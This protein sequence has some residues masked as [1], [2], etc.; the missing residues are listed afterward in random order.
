MLLQ[1][2]KPARYTGGEWNTI[3]K[4]WDKTALKISLSYPDI[5][6]IGMSNMAISILYEFFN[7]QPDVL[8]ERVFAPWVDMMQALR[9]EK[10]PL[11]S[12]ESRHA[13]REF[14]VI[15]FS[16][17]YELTFTNILSILDLAGIPLW[18]K[19][20]DDSYPLI[21]AGGSSC[22]NPEPVADF[23]DLFVIGEAEEL[24]PELICLLKEAKIKGKRLAKKFFLHQAAG[25][26]GIYVPSLYQASYLDGKYQV[27][28][29]LVPEA[30]P[31]IRRQLVSRMPQAPVKPIVPFIEI[32]HD[33]A[34]VEISRGCTRG[35]RFCNAGIIYRPVRERPMEEILKAVDDSISNTGYDEISLVSL[36]SGDYSH[37]DELVTS[38]AQK[39]GSN[40]A[41]SLPSLRLDK[42]AVNLVDRLPNRR[43]SGLTFAPEAG[44]TRLQKVINKFIPE[45]ELLAA[46]AS[47]FE[48]GWLGLKLYFMLGLPT[49]TNDDAEGIA[50]LTKK[51]QAQSRQRLPQIRL[52]IS[53][54]VPKPH[55]P[56]QWAAQES[57]EKLLSRHELLRKSLGKHGIKLSYQDTR[58]SLME[59]VMS[60]GDRRL[61]Q[62][63]Y[64]AWQDGAV[65]DGWRECFNFER[66]QKA[67]DDC[68]LDT[69]F[70]ARR[71]HAMDEPL[72]WAHIDT[73]IS[74]AFL[75]E[76]HH[77]A[78]AGELTPD[79][80]QSCNVCGLQPTECGQKP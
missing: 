39:Y 3:R 64:R 15:G 4:D 59:A 12:L 27:L 78:M 57:E 7:N 49:E 6:E 43:K 31:T 71:E 79:C 58:L 11:V 80:R 60:R 50:R 35:C 65:F 2:N 5:Y 76:E 17:G 40:L 33:R 45:E 42:H 24:L 77:R 34:A 30:S 8:A 38:I 69:N 16:L 28:S 73:G 23:I 19:D 68:Q 54:F 56:F 21:I 46:A 66:W 53:S 55:T 25:L 62:V 74:T 70:Y 32:V 63:I 36:S 41:I 72:P 67:F 48:R 29:P 14:D 20:R 52:S 18:A 1:V 9:R 61:A 22:Y 10:L 37:I 51:V 13:L 47:A 26:Q 75:K 44:S